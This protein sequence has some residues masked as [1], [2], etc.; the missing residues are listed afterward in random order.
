MDGIERRVYRRTDWRGSVRLL[1]P[2]VDP[3]DATIADISECGW[4]LRI[5]RAIDAGSEVGIDGTGFR[6]KG[7]VR[8][9]Y[10]HHGAFR[11]GIELLPPD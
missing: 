6:G 1:V 11:V 10:P 2:D 8:F 4:G 9:C 7:V 5:D 3:V